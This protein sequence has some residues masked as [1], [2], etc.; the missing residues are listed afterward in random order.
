MSVMLMTPVMSAAPWV[1]PVQAGVGTPIGKFGTPV[2][3]TVAIKGCSLSVDTPATDRQ[4]WYAGHVHSG[5][6]KLLTVC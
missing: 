6:Q 2:T 1:C 3:F 5:Y 4:V